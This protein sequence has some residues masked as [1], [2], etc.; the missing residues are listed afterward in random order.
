VIYILGGGGF[1]GSAYARLFARTGVEHRVVTRANYAQ[2]TG[3][4][5]TILINANGNSKKFLADRDPGAEFEA[6][7]VSVQRS[8]EAFKAERYVFL[9]S[10]D[11]YPTQVDPSATG[12]DQTIDPRRL[13]RYGLHKFLA[14]QLV[15]GV[16]PRHLV[17]RM[18][19]FVG[20]GLK[21]NP[22]FDLM[23]DGEVWLTPDSELQ[24]IHTDS[25]A[26]LVWALCQAGVEGRVVNL[27]GRGVVRLGDVAASLGRP[28]RF[29]PDA[30][31]VRF[32]L[33]VSDLERLTGLTPPG[34]M[35]E[36]ESFLE[37]AGVSSGAVG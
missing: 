34:S 4:S 31:K 17:V 5:C 29:R 1:V 25:A 9:S 22:I 28:G 19:G 24:Y 16:H 13:S 30:R 33:D 15:Q 12:S 6:S 37:T 26:R 23:T 3:T 7:V 35:A 2:L 20:P 8:L 32:E 27:G 11:V 18:G 21:K 14:E 36:V 10:G